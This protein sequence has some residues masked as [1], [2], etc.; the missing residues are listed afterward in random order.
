MD[1]IL[2]ELLF[3]IRIIKENQASFVDYLDILMVLSQLTFTYS[4]S[5]IEALEKGVKYVKI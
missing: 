5:T 4:K 3:S 2:D 1:V